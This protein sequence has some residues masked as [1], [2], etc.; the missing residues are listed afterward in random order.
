MMRLTQ[1]SRADIQTGKV[2]FGSFS[3]YQLA[4]DYLT[5]VINYFYI[6]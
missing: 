2:R 5:V 4:Q 6:P 1:L 3:L